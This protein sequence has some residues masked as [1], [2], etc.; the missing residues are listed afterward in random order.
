MDE[1][2]NNV[3]TLARLNASLEAARDELEAIN[4]EEGL[5]EFEQSQF[6][7]LQQLFTIKDPYEKLW[8]TALQF[9]NRSDEWL[10]G[11]HLSMKCVTSG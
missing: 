6:P 1:M 7:I 11:A 2:R 9:A 4:I 5:V 10:T 3:E 8:N